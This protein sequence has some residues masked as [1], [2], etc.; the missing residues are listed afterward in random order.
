MLMKIKEVITYYL[1]SNSHGQSWHTFIGKRP[2]NV[3]SKIDW[4]DIRT[5]Y[6]IKIS[7]Q[8]FKDYFS[9]AY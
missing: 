4:V 2:K 8:N 3:Y 6:Q 1:D 7:V 9:E 5:V